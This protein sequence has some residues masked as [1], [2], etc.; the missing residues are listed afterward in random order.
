MRAEA[1]V[2]D[3]ATGCFAAGQ[4][5]APAPARSEQRKALLINDDILTLLFRAEKRR[6][7]G[8]TKPPD[9][10]GL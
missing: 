3:L 8:K 10:R 1:A 4:H 9:Q 6:I 5:A 2:A 7:S